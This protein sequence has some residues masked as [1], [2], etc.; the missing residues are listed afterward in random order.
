MRG[1]VKSDG[2]QHRKTKAAIIESMRIPYPRRIE[3]A[4][5]NKVYIPKLTELPITV[6]PVHEYENDKWRISVYFTWN[7]QAEHV[8]MYGYTG[9][10]SDS[11][12]V[13]MAKRF[14]CLVLGQDKIEK[15]LPIPSRHICRTIIND[16]RTDPDK[17]TWYA[18]VTEFIMVA[19]VLN[20]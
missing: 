5:G 13:C 11:I 4:F 19:E 16:W 8:G 18:P 2:K 9:I 3:D 7:G 6:T 15:K 14:S 20:S 12:I 10:N 17:Q 1:P